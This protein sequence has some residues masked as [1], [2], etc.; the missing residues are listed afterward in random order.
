[1]L[2]GGLGWYTRLEFPHLNNIMQQGVQVDVQNAILRIYPQ[3]DTYSEF[4]SLPDS[5]YLYIA[6]ENNVVT[7]AVTDYLGTQVQGGVLV[8]DDTF[9]EKTYYY[10]DVS[11]FMKEELG[12]IGTNKHNLQ[13]V[14]PSAKYNST[15]NNLTFSSQKGK[16]PITLQ[17]TYTIYESY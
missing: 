8:K 5:I 11:T 4:N 2:F 16:N 15:F 13:L 10:F 12:A 3:V 9:R 1:M 7:E 14:F 17:L 6:D